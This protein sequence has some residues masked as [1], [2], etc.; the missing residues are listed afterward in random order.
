MANVPIMPCVESPGSSHGTS[1]SFFWPERFLSRN[2]STVKF[3]LPR[4][5]VIHLPTRTILTAA[6][7]FF[8]STAFASSI[9]FTGGGMNG[10]SG[11][12]LSAS[13]QFDL[14]GSTLTI[15]LTDTATSA[16][17]QYLPSDILTAVYFGTTSLAA[18]TPGT[19]SLDGSTIISTDLTDVGS[20]WEFLGG[21]TPVRG[22]VNGI[23]ASG[24]SVFGQGNFNNCTS[25]TCENLGG[26]NWGLV[27][28]FFPPS[29]G[30][31][32]GVSG[33]TLVDDRVQFTLNTMP[34]FSLASIDSVQFQWG[35]SN[36]EFSATGMTSAPE[37]STLV[38][39]GG[40]IGL[41]A[42][43]RRKRQGRQSAS[44]TL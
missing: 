25:S 39:V 37:P 36:D 10:T 19:A 2:V 29:Q 4:I 17:A 14:S 16:N 41:A 24:L 30:I 27:P 7:S 43:W 11:N 23:S 38:L 12:T 31:N 21:F 6:L 15:T 5:Q 40:G 18:L 28:S 26:I 33:R 3:N 9:T 35:T 44:Q 22:L 42:F 20:N 8:V 32:G 1:V 34:G 13:A